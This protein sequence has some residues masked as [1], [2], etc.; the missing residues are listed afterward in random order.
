MFLAPG[1][2]LILFTLT[3]NS[4]EKKYNIDKKR[5]CHSEKH[6]LVHFT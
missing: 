2:L 4:V 3:Q 1:S 6:M 5:L